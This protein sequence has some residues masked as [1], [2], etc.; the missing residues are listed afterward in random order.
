ML[1]NNFICC[2]CMTWLVHMCDMIHSHVWNSFFI[3]ATCRVHISDMTHLNMWTWLAKVSPTARWRMHVW[4]EASHIVNDLF[5][6]AQW[7]IHVC[8]FECNAF[9]VC[10]LLCD[11]WWHEWFMCKTHDFVCVTWQI[12]RCVATHSFVTWFIHENKCCSTASTCVLWGA[13]WT[14]HVIRACVMSYMNA[15]WNIWMSPVTRAWVMS[16]MNESCHMWMSH[17]TC[18]RVMSHVNESCHVCMSH[19]TYSSWCCSNVICTSAHSNAPVAAMLS[20]PVCIHVYVRVRL[21]VYMRACFYMWACMCVYAR[22]RH[23]FVYH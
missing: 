14:S 18:E 17:V 15:P 22:A 23:T 1:C 16:H 21:Y 9:F 5:T 20:A 19:V 11:I 4:H 2:E 7:P 8:S 3:C 13:M 12:C 6:R 10:L